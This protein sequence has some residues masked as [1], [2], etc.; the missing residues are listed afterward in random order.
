[1]C[2]NI[3]FNKEV[4]N[5]DKNFQVKVKVIQF[6]KFQTIYELETLAISYINKQS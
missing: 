5:F 6:L 4:G 3:Q 1:M 2:A